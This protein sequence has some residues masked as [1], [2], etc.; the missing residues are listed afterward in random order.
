MWILSP[1][2]ITYQQTDDKTIKIKNNEKRI[3]ENEAKIR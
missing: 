2:P 1:F 3:K